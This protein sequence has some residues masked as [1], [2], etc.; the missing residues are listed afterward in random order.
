[1]TCPRCGLPNPP[2]AVFCGRCGAPLAS[3]APSGPPPP[4]PPPAGPQPGV[5]G[6]SVVLACVAG[7][8]AGKRFVLGASGVTLGTALHSGLLSDDPEAAPAHAD[9]VFQNGTL[10]FR[11]HDGASL[12][13]NGAALAE[14]TLP[15]GGQL[16][17]GRSLWQGEPVPMPGPANGAVPPRA[18]GPPPAGAL[19]SGSWFQALNQRV[20]E[21]TGVSPV[22]G[23]DARE[24]FSSVLEKRTEEDVED[25][26]LVGGRATTPPIESVPAVWPKPWLFFKIFLLSLLAY[27]G[28]F[29]GVQEFGNTNCLPG[30]I[31]LGSFAI[32]L[33]VVVLY[34]EMNVPRNVSFYQVFRAILVGGVLS[35]IVSL[36]GYG[37]FG[38]G[39]PGVIE[40]VG[41][42]AALLLFVG[43]PKYRWTLN[44]LLLGGA[45][46][47][48]FA[49][50]ESA[51]Y[52][53]KAL[54]GGLALTDTGGLHIDFNVIQQTLLF[55][56]VLAP[57]G[58]VAWA[59]LEGAALWK[60]KG[61]RPFQYAMLGDGRFL[62]V[63]FLAMGLHTL[64]DIELVI[65]LPQLLYFAL[66]IGL[67]VVAWLAI[68]S[69]IQDGIK[70]VQAAQVERAGLSAPA[71]AGLEATVTP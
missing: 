9:F 46:G 3:S 22:E 15:P 4:A 48:G 44:G 24:M 53:L 30:L 43:H 62:R 68:L 55:R 10:Y 13:L 31:L 37:L 57:G 29:F 51:G 14:G 42:A 54:L 2:D 67:I 23:L 5:P 27:G 61:D 28:F 66:L 35:L 32:P 25:F 71:Q 64:W 6:P 7:P 38:G 69:F 26:F 63:L 20:G 19:P 49:G 12:F 58:H 45:I 47:A 52:A 36:F 18:A 50:F 60:V 17:V 1:M 59:A 39:L 40:E 56:G 21:V 34:F 33:T 65:R 70:Q 41:K 8:D 11:S 16:R